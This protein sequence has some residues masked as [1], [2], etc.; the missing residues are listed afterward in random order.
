MVSASQLRAGM[1]IRYEGQSYK[2]IAADYHPG[3]GKMS[4]V[5]HARLQNL[6]TGTYWEHSFRS[7][8][9][10]EDLAVE[11]QALEFL[12]ADGDQCV[13]MNPE[14]FE[15]TE[16]PEGVVGPRLR[17]LQ[18]GMKLAVE[19]VDGRPVGVLFPDILEVRI[20]DTA[21]ATHQQADSTFKP[22]KLDNG[23]DIMVPQFVKTGDVI[24]LDLATMKYID[25]VKVTGA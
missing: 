8:L 22:A 4:G 7:D 1:A 10:L 24:R 2:V 6:S 20:A 25:R 12:Y 11:K 19:F 5:T 16:V 17:F 13:F 21:P 15:Q 3:Q 18:P 14:T 9:K 23:I